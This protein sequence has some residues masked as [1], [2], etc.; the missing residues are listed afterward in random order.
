VNILQITNGKIVQATETEL[1]DF[2][3]RCGY[4]DIVSLVDFLEYCR[5]NGTEIKNRVKNV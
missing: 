5:I 3:L 2:Y 1:L 4:D